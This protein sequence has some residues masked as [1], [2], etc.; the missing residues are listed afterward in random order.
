MSIGL[1]S[2]PKPSHYIETGTLEGAIPPSE[3][4]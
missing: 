2:Y 3:V 4:T 1:L